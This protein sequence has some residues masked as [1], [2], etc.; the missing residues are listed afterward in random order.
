MAWPGT[1]LRTIQRDIVPNKAAESD[2]NTQLPAPYVPPAGGAVPVEKGDF[3]IMILRLKNHSFPR[4]PK[5]EIFRQHCVFVQQISET[6]P[7]EVQRSA[8]GVG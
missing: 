1:T 4:S 7:T 2:G 6:T 8:D 5:V 3:E